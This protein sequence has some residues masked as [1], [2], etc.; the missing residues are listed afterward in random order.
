MDIRTEVLSL[1]NKHLQ[2]VRQSGSDNITA[3]CPFHS[4]SQP[5]FAMS[6][7][8]G[9]YL[10][11]ACGAKGN[12]YTFLRDI[13]LPKEQIRDGYQHLLDEAAHNMPPEKDPLRPSVVSQDPLPESL[14]GLFDYCPRSLLEAGFTEATLGHF[15]IG[16]D[17]KHMRVTYPLRDMKGQLVGI[18]GR[19]VYDIEPRYKIY[20]DEYRDWGLEPRDP[21]DKR[22]LLWNIHTVYPDLFFGTAAGDLVLVEGFKA[23]MWLWQAGIRNVAA[24]LGTHLS[25]EHK[26]VLER[27]GGTIY[28]FLD[29]NEPGWDGAFRAGE[30]LSKTMNVRIMSYPERLKHDEKAQPDDLTPDEIHEM[31]DRAVDYFLWAAS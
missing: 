9:L 22:A 4:D 16:F 6:L 11:Y 28:L 27:L 18:S 17:Q 15:D 23:C 12:L 1:A 25:Y 31:K 3:L 29:N 7:S 8:R 2:R 10:C 5:S 21:P 14:L 19:T 13:G 26:W 24:L 20:S 30:K